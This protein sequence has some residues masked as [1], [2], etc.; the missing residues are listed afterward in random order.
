M[1]FEQQEFKVYEWGFLRDMFK[2]ITPEA[3]ADKVVEEAEE[4]YEEVENGNKE[5]AMSEAGD[6]LFS[7]FMWCKSENITPS[8]CLQIA[9]DKNWPRR[10]AWIDGRYV[11]EADLKLRKDYE[12]LKEKLLP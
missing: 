6:I 9:I 5:N 10:G 11:K 7:L 3:Q 4:F 2:H 1:L 8:Q 12:Q